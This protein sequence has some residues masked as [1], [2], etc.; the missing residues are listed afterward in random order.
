MAMMKYMG[1]STVSQN[2]KNSSKSSDM[3]TPSMAVCSSR[4]NA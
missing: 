4:K 1:T 3:N 2:T